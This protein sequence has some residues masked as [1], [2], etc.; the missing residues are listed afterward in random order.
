MQI[1]KL[2]FVCLFTLSCCAYAESKRAPEPWDNPKVPE[3]VHNNVLYVT[4]AAKN[5]PIKE[6]NEKLVDL[7]N[8]NNPRIKPLA[9]FN[10]KYKNTYKE[11]SK[12]RL[13]VY[14]KLLTMLKLLPPDV[15]IAYFEGFR[16][17][18]KQK[19]YFDNK[20]KEILAT[21]KDKELAYKETS[22]HVAPFIDNVPP[23]STGGAIDMTLFV[24]KDGQEH[25][26]NM[27]KFDV[28]FGP[29]DQQE[30]FSK[31]TTDVQRKNRLLLLEAATE[32]GLVNYG[33]EWWHYSY[34]DKMWAFVKNKKASI[35]ESV[36][37]KDDSITSIDKKTYLDSF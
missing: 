6:S 1:N 11:Y 23:H 17:L 28:L 20:L 3:I 22:K 9:T 15:G 26:M 36:A 12:V 34:G 16:P 10:P 8:I 33:F 18:Y 31:N 7:L 5:I 24:I 2:F 27:G 37:P 19:E 14:K 25:L 32:V 30:T 4:I 21:I 35:Y 29:N 13:G